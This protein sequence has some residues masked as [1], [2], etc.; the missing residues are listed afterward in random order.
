MCGAGCPP[1]AHPIL[2]CRFRPDAS[3]AAVRE[4]D[5]VTHASLGYPHHVRPELLA[6]ADGVAGEAL[7]LEVE[8]ALRRLGFGRRGER[9]QVVVLDL[10]GVGLH[11]RR[12]EPDRALRGVGKMM[13]DHDVVAIFVDD[14]LDDL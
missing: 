4:T 12:D 3:D 6:L 10:R 8:F 2:P 7:A 1:Y 11:R 14:K 9:L 13:V 5:A